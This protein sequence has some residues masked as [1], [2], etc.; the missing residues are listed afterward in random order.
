ME[1]SSFYFVSTVA[2]YLENLQ[3]YLTSYDTLLL[4]EVE[5]QVV[6]WDQFYPIL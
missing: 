6:F 5:D 3:N 2:N 4:A 1:L